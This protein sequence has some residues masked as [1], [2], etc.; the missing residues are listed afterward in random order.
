M[1]YNLVPESGTGPLITD[2]KYIM[3][4]IM[5][6]NNLNSNVRKIE[7]IHRSGAG[8][9]L[10]FEVDINKQLYSVRLVTDGSELVVITADHAESILDYESSGGIDLYG[11]PVNNNALR[12]DVIGKLARAG[13]KELNTLETRIFGNQSRL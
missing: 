1:V 5:D 12:Q 9:N 2:N 13:E 3:T 4:Y 7:Q 11:R 10:E 6:S 8:I